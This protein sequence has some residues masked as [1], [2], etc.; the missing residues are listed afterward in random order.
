MMS[1]SMSIESRKAK[2]IAECTEE[3]REEEA[4][5][6]GEYGRIYMLN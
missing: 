3:F 5:I 1:L 4:K 6:T 2:L